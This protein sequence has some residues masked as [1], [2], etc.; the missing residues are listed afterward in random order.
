[1]KRLDLSL[2]SRRYRVKDAAEVDFGELYRLY[3]SEEHYFRYFQLPM[4]EDQLRRDMTLL[5]DGCT[6]EQK[7]FLAYEDGGG[8][9]AL[10]DL[11]DGYPTDRICY[12]GLFMVDADRSGKGV[13][14]AIITELCDALSAMGYEALRLAYGKAYSQAVHFWTKNGFIPLREAVLEEYGE[15]IVAERALN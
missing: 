8:I 6:A 1:M 9:V 10:L 15:L 7:Y 11:L 14:T 2:L 4:N 12:I 5:P 3:C 13:G